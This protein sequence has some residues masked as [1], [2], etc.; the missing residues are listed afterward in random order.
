MGSFLQ[1][2]KYGWRVLWKTPAFTVIAV[3]VIA[4]GIGANTAI[5]SVID[6][7][8]LRPLPFADPER[9]LVIWEDASFMG[10]PRNTPAPANFVDWKKENRV[11]SDMAALAD[12]GLNLT[13]DG[14][15]EKLNSYATSWNAFSILGVKP[16][17]GRT[18]LPDE[19]TPG[20]EKVVLIGYG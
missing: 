10:F 3:V 20:G 16:L 19:D 13:G 17:L 5:F 11:F 9:L 7:V 6:A 12:R 15:P 1:D 14:N 18:F 8:L 4:L 2:A